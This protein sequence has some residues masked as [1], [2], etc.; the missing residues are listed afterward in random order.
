VI[1][2][3]DIPVDSEPVRELSEREI[4]S[5]LDSYAESSLFGG[6]FRG[7]LPEWGPKY[8]PSRYPT[9]EEEKSTRRR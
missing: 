5:I 2:E 9:Q 8:P 7:R 6:R 1:K 3:Q 4:I